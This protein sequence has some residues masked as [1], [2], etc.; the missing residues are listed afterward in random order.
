MY[1]ISMEKHIK[2]SEIISLWPSVGE[3]A[4]NI[5]QKETTCRGWKSRNSIPVKY[6][7]A[8]IDIAEFKK[9]KEKITVETFVNQPFK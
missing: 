7:Q 2:H 1:Y 5:G 4:R 9:F 8:I 6:W 3:F